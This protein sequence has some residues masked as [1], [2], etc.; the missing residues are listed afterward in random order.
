MNLN[1]NPTK[2]K[3]RKLLK[4][5]DDDAGVHILWV[6]R[7]GE[8]NITLLEEETTPAAWAESMGD[9]IRFRYETYGAG[10]GYIG[11]DAAQ[12]DS[13]VSLLFQHLGKDWREGALGYIDI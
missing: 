9:R 6:D 10:N 11:P 1:S 5:C 7:Q 8:V 12:D 13:Y 2:A 3:L 4:S